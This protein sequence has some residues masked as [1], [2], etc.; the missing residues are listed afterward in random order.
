[1]GRTL[2][3]A[4]GHLLERERYE[5]DTRHLLT[6]SLVTPLGNLAL[7]CIAA[8]ERIGMACGRL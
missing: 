1:M 8:D 2:R 4:E 3:L 6:L 7:A 5:V